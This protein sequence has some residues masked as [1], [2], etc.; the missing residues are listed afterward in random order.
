[1]KLI[2]GA[3]GSG[4]TRRVLAQYQEALAAPG[5]SPRIVVPTATLVRHLQHE[6]ARAGVIFPPRTIL[7][8]SGFLRERAAG[9][10]LAPDGLVRALVRDALDRLQLPEFA[11]VVETAGL[12]DTILETI[13][14]FDNAACTPDQLRRARKVSPQ[15]RAFEQIWREVSAALKDRGFVTRAGWFAAAIE[16]REP[17][18]VWFDGFQNLG[19]L[20]RGLIR[21]IDEHSD[22]TLT[23]PDGPAADDMHRFA[24]SLGAAHEQVNGQPRRPAVTVVQARSIERE[25]DELARRILQMHERGRAWRE[26]AVALRDPGT[27]ESP[28]RGTFERFGIPARFYFASPLRTHPASV[29]LSGLIE[30]VLS[31]WDFAAALDAFRA[32]PAWGAGAAFD[33]FD[34]AVREVLPG[35]GAARLRDLAGED[36]R[37]R[38]EACLAFDIWKQGTLRPAQWVTR[39]ERMARGLYYPGRIEP[40]ADEASLAVARG[41][42]QALDSWIGAV[43]EAELFWSD[44]DRPIT[45]AE[46]W[47]VACE[48]VGGFSLRIADERAD[49][50]HVMS[51]WE[52]RQWELGALFVCGM[53]NRDYPRRAPQNLLFPDSA[54]AALRRS[55]IELRTAADADHDEEA[56]WNS[57]RTRARGELVLTYPRH[58]ASGKAIE[59]SRWLLDVEGARE[60]AQLCRPAVGPVRRGNAGL[61]KS[62]GLLEFMSGRHR[63]IGITRLEDLAV[64]RFK[65]FAGRTLELKS[66]PD[67]PS[68]R[69]QPRTTG[70]ILHEALQLWLERKRQGDF[71]ELFEQAFDNVCRKSNLPPGYRLEVER[72]RYREI[73]R[74]V[75]VSETWPLIA[76]LAEEPV[77]VE[78]PGG[79]KAVGRVDRIDR[80]SD[81]ACLIVDYKSGKVHRVESLVESPTKLQGPLYALGVKQKF[82][83]DVLAMMYIAVREDQRFGWGVIP[84]SDPGELKPIPENWIEDALAR[85]AGQVAEFLGGRIHAGPSEPD[86]C[87]W[88][89]FESTCR[90]EERREELIQIG[91]ADA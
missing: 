25:G 7:S 90:V 28:L 41:H 85:T 26:M 59:T 36:I 66:R 68:E 84:G 91:A 4:K 52:A 39:L 58:D 18:R 61:I 20:E 40:A 2:R 73:A 1:V 29:F 13:A 16:N 10:N 34:F 77:E 72:M 15:A 46:F 78:L 3:S 83:W 50:V 62:P 57:L 54:I 12:T 33:R 31:N 37:E 63:E 53:T 32:H 89:D 88:C 5:S 86:G 74:G 43:A 81:N 24:M 42:A 70:L 60:N 79:V 23:L 38:I 69:L 82:G 71:V 51:A 75:S 21:A 87:L 55:G 6:V 11:A 64:C 8:L 19:S 35:N 56:L 30:C 14:L 65:F 48:I 22:V 80:V 9:V 17:L 45:L 44:R 67:L 47:R 49:V 76:S 27:Y